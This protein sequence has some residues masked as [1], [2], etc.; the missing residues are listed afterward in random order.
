MK[1]TMFLVMAA[2]LAIGLSSQAAI[3]GA[4]G[5]TNEYF[6]NSAARTTSA[7]TVERSQTLGGASSMMVEKTISAPGTIERSLRAPV[8]IEDRIIKQ[9][10]LFGIGIWPLFD[11]EIL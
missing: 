11:F 8:V 2:G 1:C 6:V 4:Q 5:D 3:A 7:V 9:K 10:H